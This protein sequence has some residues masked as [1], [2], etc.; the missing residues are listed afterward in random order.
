MPHVRTQVVV[1]KCGNLPVGRQLQVVVVDVVW[2]EHLA[3]ATECGEGLKDDAVGA[4]GIHG[5]HACDFRMVGEDVSNH[6]ESHL[7][8]GRGAE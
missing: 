2:D 4:E 8:I 6:L 1:Q 7:F 3:G 5:I